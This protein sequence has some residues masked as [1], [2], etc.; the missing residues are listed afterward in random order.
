MCAVFHVFC[1]IF[2]LFC[3]CVTV[4]AI[5]DTVAAFYNDTD[6]LSGEFMAPPGVCTSLIPSSGLLPTNND[7]PN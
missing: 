4:D 6:L 7:L 3:C 5:N 2:F 1:C